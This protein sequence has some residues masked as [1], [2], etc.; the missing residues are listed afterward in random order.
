MVV[1]FSMNRVKPAFQGFIY[2]KN[3]IELNTGLKTIL[4]WIKYVH[5]HMYV[6]YSKT[7]IITLFYF[8]CDGSF[9]VESTIETDISQ[10]VH[11]GASKY[12][13]EL[14]YFVLLKHSFTNTYT[15]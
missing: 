7:F 11:R 14:Q 13:F 1:F 4:C 6:G 2:C 10:G 15:F 3:D 12:V 9:E 8:S 5:I